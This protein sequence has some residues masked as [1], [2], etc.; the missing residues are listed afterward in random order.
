MQKH[1][2]WTWM[3]GGK[4]SGDIGCCTDSAVSHGCFLVEVLLLYPGS[5]LAAALYGCVAATCLSA[6]SRG[7]HCCWTTSG[8]AGNGSRVQPAVA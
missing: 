8:M 3:L 1:T 7:Q 4:D 6:C 2:K 5:L